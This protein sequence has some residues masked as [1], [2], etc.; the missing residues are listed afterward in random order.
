MVLNIFYPG[1]IIN[2]KFYCFSAQYED[3]GVWLV[4]AVNL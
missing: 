1:E 4:Q 2:K 3:L